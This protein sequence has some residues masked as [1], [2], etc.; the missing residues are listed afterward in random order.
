MHYLDYNEKQ[1]HGTSGFPLGFYRVDETHPRYRMPFHWHK[2]WELL[3]VVQGSITLY[4]EDET[5]E[6]QTGD[7]VFILDGMI[8]GGEPDDCV[9]EC[10]VFDP[11]PLSR[12][13]EMCKQC[14][15]PILNRKI[16]VQNHFTQRETA[17]L[18]IS[19]H[20]FHSGRKKETGSQLVTLGCLYELFGVSLQKGYY[21]TRPPKDGRSGEK[22]MALKPV[23]ELIERDFS[24]RLTLE[25]LSRAAG[26]SPKYFCRYFRAITH[27]TPI[28]YLNFCRVEHGAF[29]LS[30]TGLSVAETA[31][32][33][34]FEDPSYF[35]RTFKKYKG[36]TPK[37]YRQDLTAPVSRK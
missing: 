33:C 15:Q 22:M 37:Q 26:M 4:L 25:D 10:I 17:L 8:H 36:I 11:Q 1:Q 5:I 34:G 3:R 13:S 6:A 16:T 9:Y 23:F 28:D 14:L 27:R 24:A 29:L 30:G 20:L 7:L 21:D 31:Y 19:Q 18:R 2:E 35:I 12:H 32:R